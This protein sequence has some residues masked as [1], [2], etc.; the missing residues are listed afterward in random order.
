[1]KDSTILLLLI[2]AIVIV[3]GCV[4]Q[5]GSDMITQNNQQFK[6]IEG[7]TFSLQIPNDWNYEWEKNVEYDTLMI[8]QKDSSSTL[9]ITP[10]TIEPADKFSDKE[11]INEQVTI[12]KERGI[13]V[14][15]FEK[16]CF[17]ALSYLTESESDPSII[18]EYW[19]LAKENRVFII[20][21]TMEKGTESLPSIKKELERV[22][23]M[24]FAIKLL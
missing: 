6:V 5:N 15:T 11:Y 16:N 12:E 8:W 14:Q 2:L 3:S 22:E 4:S 9:R 19:N 23:E 24:I 20:S 10:L 18:Q 7:R 21:F 13:T 1:M 17:Q